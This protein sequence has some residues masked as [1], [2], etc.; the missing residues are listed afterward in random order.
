MEKIIFGIFFFILGLIVG[1]FL[2]AVIY[3][4]KK[5]E[6]FVRGR[7]YCPHCSHELSFFDL[8]PVFSFIMLKGRCR[9]CNEKISWQYPLV[10]IFTGILFT[11]SYFWIPFGGIIG[12]ITLL[13][14]FIV[15]SLVIIVFV[16]D[17]RYFLIPS[18]VVYLLAGVALLYR[19]IGAFAFFKN[20][21]DLVSLQA[22]VIPLVSGISAAGFFFLIWAISKGSWMG[23]GDSE[24]ALFIGIF[25][26]F[27]KTI[28]A[29]FI[30]FLVGSVVG[31]ALVA[32]DKKGFKSEVPFAPFLIFGT[33][34]AFFWGA[35]IISWY[36]SI[37]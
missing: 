21:F 37:L 35:E 36:L 9:Y 10:E 31:L 32:L 19:V 34:L 18:M 4:M 11:L 26:G 15:F 1:S 27:P 5:K 7:S 28:L 2:N 25:L 24:V 16:Y 33:V 3:R 30:A 29:L 20:G 6:S 12:S 17:L 8:I 13:Y 14:L 23:L 22:I